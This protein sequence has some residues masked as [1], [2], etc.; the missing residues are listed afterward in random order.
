VIHEISGNQVDG[1]IPSTE[2]V[3]TGF[4]LALLP[5]RIRQVEVGARA[6]IF[7]GLRMRN[8]R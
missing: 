2:F 6:F 8:A 4:V 5:F 7:I 3:D 1:S